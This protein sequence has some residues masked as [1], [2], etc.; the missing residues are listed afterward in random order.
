MDKMTSLPS[1]FLDEYGSSVQDTMMTC[2]ATSPIRTRVALVSGSTILG[3]AAWCR[4]MGKKRTDHGSRG[5]WDAPPLLD[6][7]GR[8]R[9]LLQ[10][11]F[12]QPYDSDA[13]VLCVFD[14]ESYYYTASVGSGD[15][16]GVPLVNWMT[17]GFY[18][19]GVVFDQIRLADLE[20]ADLGRYKVVAFMNTWK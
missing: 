14:T 12:A 7:I 13:D 20:R 11:R 15:P 16:I 17:L 10:E 18:R 4:D 9:A 8:V 5:W 6:D 19:A 2:D 1:L 3:R